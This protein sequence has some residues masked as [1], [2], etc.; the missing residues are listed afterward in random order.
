MTI[1]PGHLRSAPVAQRLGLLPEALRRLVELAQR[2]VGAQRVVLFGSR[3]RGDAR[4]RSDLDIAVEPA[5]DRS[6]GRFVAETEEQARTLLHIDLVNLRRCQPALLE[7]IE[8]EGI[9]IYEKR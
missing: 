4:P 6:W 3:A 7:A 2:H 9:V 8:R 1:D 5:D